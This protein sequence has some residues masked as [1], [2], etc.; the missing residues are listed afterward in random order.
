M[1]ERIWNLNRSRKLCTIFVL[2]SFIGVGV[3]QSNPD[4]YSKIPEKNR[5]RFVARITALIEYEKTNKWE[6]LYGILFFGVK[7]NETIDEYLKRRRYWAKEFPEDKILDFTPHTIRGPDNYSINEWTVLGCIKRSEKGRIKYFE[8]MVSAYL[9]K[10]DWF[11]SEPGIFVAVD[12]PSIECNSQ[13]K[14]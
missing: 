5:D 3:C 4:L 10:D 14:K 2:F 8:G 12:G 13:K 6:E 7:Q 9:E 11:F 1:V